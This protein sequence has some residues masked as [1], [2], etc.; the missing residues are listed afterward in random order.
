MISVAY[1]TFN[2][3]KYIERSIRSVQSIAD[4]IIVLD[5]FSEDRTVNICN[6]FGARVF[7]TKW[8][9]DFSYSKNIAASLC[10]EPWI[11]FLDADEHLE[12]ENLDLIKTAIDNS[13]GGDIVSWSFIRKNHYPIHEHDSPFY[14]PPF[15]PDFQVRLFRNREEIYFSGAV[16]EGVLASI[17]EGKVGIVGRLSVCLHHH[18]FRGDK[19]KF[20]DL[21]GLYY[22]KIA[23]GEFN[24][25]RHA[26]D[27]IERD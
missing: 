22:S 6:S 18:M 24:E 16:H 11:L 20:E 13:V 9:H 15:Y 21:K 8:V 10:S 12:G 19:E 25:K 14:G 4:E 26:I 17:K 1:I 7:Q 23:R 27:K 2:E 3:E 5:H